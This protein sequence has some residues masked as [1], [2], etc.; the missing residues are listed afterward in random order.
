MPVLNLILTLISNILITWTWIKVINDTDTMFLG[1]FL[2]PLFI[3]TVYYFILIVWSIRLF[4][5]RLNTASCRKNQ[6][7]SLFFM[8]LVPMLLV[9]YFTT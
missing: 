5:N 6:E 3:F 4:K 9:Y 1:L 8:N 2:I 7:L